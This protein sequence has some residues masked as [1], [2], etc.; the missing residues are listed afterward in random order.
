MLTTISIY[1]CTYSVVATSTIIIKAFDKGFKS[2]RIK[3]SSF[4]QAGSARTQDLAS[5]FNLAP[6]A[7]HKSFIQSKN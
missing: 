2:F 3:R 1:Y 5:Y 6:K 7:F 4:K